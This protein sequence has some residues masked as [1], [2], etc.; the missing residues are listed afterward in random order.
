MSGTTH[1]HDNRDNHPLVRLAD[2]AGRIFYRYGDNAVAQVLFGFIVYLS[3]A[4]FCVFTA[5]GQALST[6]LL[7][8]LFSIWNLFADQIGLA[9][10]DFFTT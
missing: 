1:T 2:L 3:L 10:V 7:A 6:D 8:V 4:L 9:R 5:A